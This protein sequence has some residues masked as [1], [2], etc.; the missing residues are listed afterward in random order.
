M[1]VIK[2]AWR[3]IWV[4]MGKPT[5]TGDGR[6]AYTEN[7]QY[8]V[9]SRNPYEVPTPP[10]VIYIQFY[11]I[12]KVKIQDGD[13][14]YTAETQ[15]NPSP[16]MFIRGK[17]RHIIDIRKDHPNVPGLDFPDEVIKQMETN[18]FTSAIIFNG[19]GYGF[20][21]TRLFI[22]D[23]VRRTGNGGTP[24]G[25]DG[26]DSNDQRKSNTTRP[27]HRSSESQKGNDRNTQRGKKTGT[28]GRRKRR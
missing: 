2:E 28:S 16:L 3:E 4:S 25:G 12:I 24:E 17:K 22:K 9:T 14:Q 6:L 19:Q 10:E 8:R 23:Y 7:V 27:V 5:I 21:K 15:Q 20:D 18:G 13:N 26:A 1:K 11:D